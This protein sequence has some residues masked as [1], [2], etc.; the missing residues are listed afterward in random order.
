MH[1]KWLVTFKMGNKKQESKGKKDNSTTG[2][3]ERS[4]CARANLL[5]LV[6][7]GLLQSEEMVQ[8]KP[9]FRQYVLQEDVDQGH[10]ELHRCPATNPDIPCAD[11]L[12]PSAF[13]KLNSSRFDSDLLTDEE[14]TDSDDDV[15][16]AALLK[17]SGKEASS[18]L[19]VPSNPTKPQGVVRKCKLVLGGTSDDNTR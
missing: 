13:R 10:V 1:M 8:W 7:Q 6:A 4:K 5:N 14:L 2:D 11:H 18:S 3:W 16:L 19:E 15:P 12:K 9:S 17:K